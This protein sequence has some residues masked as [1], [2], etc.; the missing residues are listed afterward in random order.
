ML[1]EKRRISS[2][3]YVLDCLVNQG[4]VERD[5][6]KVPTGLFMNTGEEVGPNAHFQGGQ[7]R[8]RVLALKK[9]GSRDAEN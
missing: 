4:W 1:E 5:G 2:G 3:R 8:G 9:G 7:E 6:K